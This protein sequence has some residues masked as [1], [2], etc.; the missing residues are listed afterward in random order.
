MKRN[1]DFSIKVNLRPISLF[2]FTMSLIIQNILAEGKNRER[3]VGSFSFEVNF[4]V[5]SVTREY[6]DLW[7]CYSIKCI[8]LVPTILQLTL[9]KRLIIG[10]FTL[11][12]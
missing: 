6:G 12:T 7:S 8:L 1:T 10:Q 4:L 5:S 11:S 9:V 2:R 3:I